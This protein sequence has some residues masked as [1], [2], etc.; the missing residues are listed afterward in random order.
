MLVLAADDIM[1]R[2]QQIGA[3]VVCGG[4]QIGE[5]HVLVAGHARDRGFAGDVGSGEGLDHLLTKALLVIEHIMR[6]AEPRGDVPRIVDVLPRAAR[7]LAMRRFAVVVELHRDADDVV[8]LES[9]HRRHDGRI[10][11]ARHR[12]DDAGFGRGLG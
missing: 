5:F 3:E 4:V 9:E 10:D 11:P 7:A 1:A 12:D 6:N 8:A 2:R